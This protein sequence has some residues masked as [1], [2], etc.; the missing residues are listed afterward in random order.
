MNIKTYNP[1]D[2][3]L[4]VSVRSKLDE[5]ISTSILENWESVSISYADSRY[6]YQTS[7][8]GQIIRSKV[9]NKLGSMEI[10]S[11]NNSDT[12]RILNLL[13]NT[14]HYIELS[15]TEK[16]GDA[17]ATKFVLSGGAVEDVGTGTRGR[18]NEERTLVVTG[19]VVKFEENDYFNPNATTE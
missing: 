12:V 6:T 18:S 9:I 14:D 1:E 16:I 13:K 7:T 8:T 3:T 5:F 11:P 17:I 4:V 2:C 10:V 19:E 15:F